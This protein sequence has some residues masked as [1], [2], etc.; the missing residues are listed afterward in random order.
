MKIIDKFKDIFGKIFNKKEEIKALPEARYEQK[1]Y[2]TFHREDG[3]SFDIIPIVDKVGN[4]VY[5][6][7][8]NHASNQIQYLPKY[9]I[10]SNEVQEINGCNM[11]SILM[12]IDRDVLENPQ[13]SNYIANVFLGAKKIPKIMEEYEKYA[14]GLEIRDTGEITEK[15]DQG[16]ISG[17]KANR[18]QNFER[19]K[20]EQ[21]KREAQLQMEMKDKAKTINVNI[22]TSHAEELSGR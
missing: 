6:Q 4:Q 20:Q 1:N 17:L 15:L 18:Q 2:Y 9:C 14:G 10:S 3:T 22:K 7:V 19:Y 5:E 13:Y 21:A 16:I 11:T 8:L 12:D